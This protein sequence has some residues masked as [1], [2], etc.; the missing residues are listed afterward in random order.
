VSGL[1]AVLLKNL[2]FYTHDLI[3]NG[4]VFDNSNYLYFALPL[5]G[6]FITV[7][8]AKFIIKDDIG[9][10]V[11]R[12]LYAISRRH[13]NIKSHNMYSSMIGSTFTVGFGGSVG[14]EAPIVLTGSSFGSYLGRLFKLNHKTI[15]TLIGAGATG[16]IAGI[17][18]APVAAVV[19]SLEVLMIDLTMGALIPLLISAATGAVVSF[20]LMGSSV[21]FTFNL[22]EDFYIKHIPYY[23]GLGLFTG[24]VSLYFTRMTLFVERYVKRINSIYLRVLA[25]GIALGV[26]IFILPSLYGEGYEFLQLLIN[27]EVDGLINKD[28]INITSTPLYIAIFLFLII[29]FKVIAM[30]V[31]NGSGGV[32]GIFAPSLFVGGVSGFFYARVLSFFDGVNIPEKNMALV[33]MSGVMAG[34]MHAPL[35]GIFLIA[36]ITGG[37]QLFTPLIITA[38][39][40]YLT[41]QYFEP[42]SIYTK[43]LAERGEL[44]TH[45]KDRSVL[46]MMNVRNH[47]ENDFSTVDKDATLGELVRIIS[48]SKR[49][50]FPVVDNENNFYGVVFINDIRNI[51]FNNELYES[52]LVSNIMYMPDPIVSPDESMEEVAQKFQ[53]SG[54]YNLPVIDYGKYLGFVSRARIFSTYQ[55]LLREFSEE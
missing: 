12:I 25:G 17:F 9:H 26:F 22:I 51:V 4:F 29:I 47:I 8:F 32:G 33:G 30:A 41:I 50:V 44:L 28:L 15:M 16:A 38:T 53:N 13:G 14:L 55:K 46:Q 20:F 40:S 19:F 31:T 23:I 54:H 24:L 1:A 35:T 45:H 49:N 2:V 36:E 27:N 11:S 3:T 18:D 43:N 52:T 42:H 6:I 10:G 34:V 21:L 39:I 5:I 37:Y 7:L 48:H